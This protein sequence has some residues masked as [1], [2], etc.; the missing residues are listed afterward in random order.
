[1]N[2]FAQVDE[3]VR[4]NGNLSRLFSA[5]KPLVNAPMTP[6]QL[7]GLN[8][9]FRRKD[10]G[11]SCAR[12]LVHQRDAIFT[13]G[14]KT[15][16]EW[17]TRRLRPEVLDQLRSG[18]EGSSVVIPN[19][20]V[21]ESVGMV[22]DTSS[23]LRL[24]K[25][26]PEALKDLMK[27]GVPPTHSF[28]NM[29]LL[30]SHYHHVHA[31]VSG[32]VRRLLPIHSDYPLFGRSTLN[33]CEIESSIGQVFML[34]VGEAVVQDFRYAVRSGSKVEQ[35]DPLGCFNWGSQT[36]LIFPSGNE[37]IKVRPRRYAFVGH[38]VL[39]GLK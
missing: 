31:P 9:Y 30:T 10:H 1:M 15:Y 33:F 20:C 34:M 32:Y 16:L 5:L 19:E 14:H 23:I 3:L 12:D 2:I 36:V 22:G 6:E 21:I 25:P 37:S 7:A 13:G 11:L 18:A 28:V 35:L 24:K 26:A 38:R 29:K 39:G 8:V 4:T 17:F 27:L